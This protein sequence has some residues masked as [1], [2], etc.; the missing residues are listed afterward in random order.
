MS[1]QRRYD[2]DLSEM[3]QLLLQRE[4]SIAPGNFSPLSLITGIDTWPEPNEI[5]VTTFKL[6]GSKQKVLK[7]AKSRTFET[8]TSCPAGSLPD[9][10]V[11]KQ[12]N[13]RGSRVACIN[14][15]NGQLERW[16]PTRQ[17]FWPNIKNWVNTYADWPTLRFGFSPFCSECLPNELFQQTSNET[18]VGWAFQLR[19]GV[20]LSDYI[21]RIIVTRDLKADQRPFLR[22]VASGDFALNESQYFSEKPYKNGRIGT[23]ALPARPAAFGL[24]KL[25]DPALIQP[26]PPLPSVKG[27]PGST[28]ARPT[29][30]TLGG[31][32]VVSTNTSAQ[33]AI[34]LAPGATFP[35]PVPPPGLVKV[36]GVALTKETI[37]LA[38]AGVIGLYLVTR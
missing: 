24:P 32:S 25:T 14:I 10:T 4:Q 21:D 37:A 13:Q 31:N 28:Q 29:T 1:I 33:P 9:P 35:G 19:Y 26:T 3:L 17:R 18:N 12:F 36:F 11:L 2:V 22:S 27:S 34:N 16:I 5:E 8:T 23:L 20:K 7:S 15:T 6:D 38:A 30:N